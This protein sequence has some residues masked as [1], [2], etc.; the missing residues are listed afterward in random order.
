M[1]VL[2]RNWKYTITCTGYIT[3]PVLQSHI[4]VMK[5]VFTLLKVAAHICRGGGMFLKVEG[6]DCAKGTV[7]ALAVA[8]EAEFILIRNATMNAS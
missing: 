7:Y 8:F 2:E 6:L 3:H 4:L 1:G 5:L